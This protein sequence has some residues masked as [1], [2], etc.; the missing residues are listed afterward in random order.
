MG[1]P[2]S[3]NALCVRPYTICK[4]SSRMAVLI[5]SQTR[6]LLSASRMVLP[7][8]IS[9]AIAAECVMPLQPMSLDQRFFDNALF[10][11]Q[12][13]LAGALLRCAPANAVRQGR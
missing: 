10:H 12:R 6:S 1:S 13:E 3:E 5:A 7:G 2:S 9:A 8:R 11:V 4:N